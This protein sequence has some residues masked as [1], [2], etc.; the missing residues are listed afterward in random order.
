[1]PADATC[2]PELSPALSAVKHF[3]GKR[4][5]LLAIAACPSS[6]FQLPAE[7]LAI[8]LSAGRFK[9]IH[10]RLQSLQLCD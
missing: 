4:S 10:D 7:R 2:N 5:R 8:D 3:P 9:L 1:L 6:I